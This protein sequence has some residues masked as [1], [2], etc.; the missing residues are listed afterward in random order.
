M[1]SLQDQIDAEAAGWRN[2][3][4]FYDHYGGATRGSS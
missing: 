1:K 4:P 2:T 3:A